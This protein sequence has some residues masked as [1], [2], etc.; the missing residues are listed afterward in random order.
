MH[1][2]EIAKNELEVNQYDGILSISGDGL[3]HEIINGLMSRPD[4][5]EFLNSITFGFIPAG[6]GN[7]L[8][9]T[10]SEMAGENYGILTSAFTIAKGRKMKMDLTELELQYLKGQERSKIYMFLSLAWAIIADIDINSEVIRF[11]GP[12]RFTIWGL[13]RFL[14][15]RRY[16]G[17]ITFKGTEIKNNSKWVDLKNNK[18]ALLQQEKYVKVD[19]NETI[20]LDDTFKHLMVFNVNWVS[21]NDN[22]APLAQIMDGTNDITAHTNDKRR[23]QLFRMLIDQENGDFFSGPNSP[24]PGQIKN[25]HG[26]QYYKATEWE[27]QPQVKGPVPDDIENVWPEQETNANALIAI[28]GERYPAQNISGH[29]MKQVLPIYY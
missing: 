10:I 8:V 29:V 26:T 28:D 22:I 14:F 2:F 12:A 20:I 15:V 18:L 3:V 25:N 6:T 27:F 17:K 19:C 4:R 13:Y 23:S 16:A 21:L 7:G 11:A 1:A 9:K 24:Q 5:E